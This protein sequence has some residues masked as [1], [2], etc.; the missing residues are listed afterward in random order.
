[1]P[2]D[3]TDYDLFISYARKDNKPIP[4]TYPKGWVTAIRDHIAEDHRKF[5]T[6]PLGIF[7]DHDEIKGMD[8][9]RSRILGA[10][11]KSKMLLVCLSPNYFTSE[12]CFWEW[13][14]YRQREVHKLMGS[15]SVATI[16]F[17]EALGFDDEDKA[18]WKKGVLVGN[19]TDLRPWFPDGAEAL[20]KDDVRARMSQLGQSLWDRLQRARRAIAVPGNLRWQN[21]HFVG[22]QEELRQLHKKLGTG[23]VGVVTAVH[24]LGGQGKTELAVA[25]AH[26][27]ADGYPAGLWSL[28]A[29]GKKELLPLIGELAWEPALK[30]VPTETQKN[31]PV[32]LGRAVL[33]DLKTRA[34][35]V[36]DNDPDKSAA[37]LI[38]LDNVSETALLS[39][40]QLATLPGGLSAG[41][42]NIVA[43][44][45]LDVT[46]QKDRLALVAVDSLDDESA[47]SLIRDHQPPRDAQRQIVADLSQGE[48]NFA[49][50]EEEEVARGIVRALGGFTLAIEQV[51]IYLGL[52]TEVSPT[53]FLARLK[54]GGLLLTD[55]IPQNDD[56]VASR[57]LTQTKQLGLILDSTL[58]R[59]DEAARTVLR[60]AALLPPDHVP[61]PWLRELTIQ[62]HPELAKKDDLG[63]DPWMSIQRRL[64]GL[65]LLSDGDY[66]EIGRIHR[67]VATHITDGARL[68]NFD[69]E[70][71]TPT[72]ASLIDALDNYLGSRS[73]EL[74]RGRMRLLIG[75]WTRLSS[76]YR[77]ASM[78]PLLTAS[79]RKPSSSRKNFPSTAPWPSPPNFASGYTRLSKGTPNRMR[80]TRSGSETSPSRIIRLGMS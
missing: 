1:M 2:S 59:L 7:L 42:L 10:L 37:A 21:P 62:L 24:G 54:E 57:M 27:W 20:Q 64:L 3:Q 68:T 32:L 8:D 12:Y 77:I 22:R 17:V 61:W 36:K 6:T 13:W 46:E 15:D 72:D 78:V 55:D 31:D 29:E 80:Q 16:Y 5:S 34:A 19:Y 47:L 52:H 50:P 39:S 35:A 26:G 58:A 67:L 48:P 73:D 44:T 23:S 74:Y 38:L 76:S 60:F 45:R 40:A 18:R 65:R 66:E 11:K 53:E 49:G 63:A 33:E 79:P 28:A 75:S 30:F 51:A 70:S 71:S 41:W 43:T 4:E 9:W 56:E 25:Y 14:E 69:E